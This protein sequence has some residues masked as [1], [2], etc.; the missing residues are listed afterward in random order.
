MSQTTCLLVRIPA[1][2]CTHANVLLLMHQTPSNPTLRIIYRE[3]AILKVRRAMQNSKLCSHQ[4]N[5][6][7]TSFSCPK[8]SSSSSAQAL[9]SIPRPDLFALTALGVV[10]DVRSGGLG[11]VGA[12]SLIGSRIGECIRPGELVGNWDECRGEGEQ[13][14]LS[15]GTLL[16]SAL[17]WSRLTASA[18][19]LYSS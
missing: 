2:P 6:N 1:S 16:C 11:S 15:E 5:D 13:I 14:E 10:E 19:R 9:C 18:E 12:F 17:R 3:N 4:P 8:S 7:L